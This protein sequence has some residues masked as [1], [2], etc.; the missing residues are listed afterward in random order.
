MTNFELTAGD[1]F[2]LEDGERFALVESGKVEVYAVT[3]ADGSFRQQFL[4]EL[5]SGGAAFPSLDEFGQTE[6]QIHAV[7]DSRIQIFAFNEIA[8]E[9]LKIFM[10]NWFAELIKLPW[11]SLLADKGD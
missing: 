3:R 4:A 11:L 1:R 8:P 7:E 9:E 5:N 10:R 2:V 6:T